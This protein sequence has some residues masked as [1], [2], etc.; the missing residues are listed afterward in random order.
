MA[1]GRVGILQIHCIIHLCALVP[2]YFIRPAKLKSKH[3]LLANGT[4]NYKGFS[5]YL[6]DS[7]FT[8][9]NYLQ[10]RYTSTLNTAATAGLAFTMV[11]HITK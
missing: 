5:V 3:F 6:R 2:S 9:D 7:L 8:L 10:K 11:L 1:I 4:M